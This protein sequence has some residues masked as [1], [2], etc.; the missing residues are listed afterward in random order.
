VTSKQI[1]GVIVKV[2][3]GDLEKY[4]TTLHEKGQK[5][6]QLK[7]LGDDEEWTSE[8]EGMC[9]TTESLGKRT[10]EPVKKESREMGPEPQ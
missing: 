2:P 6:R 5:Q 7:G 3:A 10:S 1:W 9:M 4:W 8:K